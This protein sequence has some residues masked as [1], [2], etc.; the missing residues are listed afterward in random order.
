MPHAGFAWLFA[1]MLLT[2]AADLSAAIAP[3]P[4]SLPAEPAVQAEDSL[5]AYLDG[6]SDALLR[7]TQLPGLAV[8]VVRPDRPDLLAGYG[9]AD[10]ERGL[11][12]DGA[13]TLFRIGSVSK[14]F[15]WTAVMI[16][17]E[18]G[19]LDLDTDVNRYLRQV[20]VADAFDTPVTLNHLM[21]HRAG[22]EDT[23]A[24]F[25]VSDDDPRTLAEL[26]AEHQPR[27]VYPPGARTSYSNWGAALAAQIVADVSGEDYESFLRSHI[28]RPLALNSTVIEPPGRMPDALQAR[29]AKGY[30]LRQG[31][32]IEG[33]PMQIGAY[34]PAG[35]MAST[36][37]DMARWMRFH[38]N[39]G[40]LDGIRLL[41]AET[42]ARMRERGFDDQAGAADVAHGF[43]SRPHRGIDTLGH[44][45]ATGLYRAQL[46]LAPALGVAVFAAQNSPQSGYT[47]LNAITDLI[48]EREAGILPAAPVGPT[49]T[50]IDRDLTEF[51]GG[52][53]NNRRAFGNLTA[54]FAIEETIR[55]SL[56]DG[57]GLSVTGND[58]TRHYRPIASDRDLFETDSGARIRF[59]RD[60]QGRIVAV[61]DGS[62]VHSHERVP[63]WQ[64]SLALLAAL[65]ATGLFAITTLLG[66]WWRWRR[67]MVRTAAGLFAGRL[68]AGTALAV[69]A[70][71]ILALAAMVTLS[72]LAVGDL[73]AYPPPPLRL[74]SLAGWPLAG[75]AVLMLLA[76][77][78]VWRQSKWRTGRRLHFSL[79]TL[80]LGFLVVQLWQWRL[81]AAPL[82]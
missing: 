57:G 55:I 23:L 8:A 24:L 3:T 13:E 64:S 45:G 22:F 5:P 33:K 46:L 79:F 30:E 38:L 53:R 70:Y 27:R 43:Q 59:Q 21:A 7:D 63:P 4:I 68:A 69:L 18:R 66:A 42:H 6:L 62:G 50:T 36:A 19:Q 60:R 1:T 65:A 2:V 17:V 15:I 16:L 78:P 39:G 80:A 61:N 31:R 40:E 49:S 47:A 14:T 67:P 32:H 48:L 73:T 77:R 10:V 54:I 81:F 20:R 41:S 44:G 58:Q 34:W 11:P 12:V 52:Y 29:L 74:L 75:L 71:L 26:L 35:G 51:L 76:L 72:T 56:A 82:I 28:L 9:F 37:A 25:M